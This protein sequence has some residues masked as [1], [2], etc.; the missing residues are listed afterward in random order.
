MN[1]AAITFVCVYC[2]SMLTLILRMNP[3]LFI[4]GSYSGSVPSLLKNIHSGV[5]IYIPTNTTE[6]LFSSTASQ[7]FV[8]VALFSYS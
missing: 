4:T 5:L 1:C 3:E 2:Y 6:V 7:D 8:T